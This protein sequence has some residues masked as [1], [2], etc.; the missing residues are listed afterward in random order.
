MIPGLFLSVPS[1][2]IGRRFGDK[3]LVLIGLTLMFIGGAIA[4]AA[5]SYNMIAQYSPGSEISLKSGYFEMICKDN[6]V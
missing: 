2:Y 5:D 6:F 1:G 3:L 4:G